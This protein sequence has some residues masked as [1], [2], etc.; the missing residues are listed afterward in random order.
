MSVTLQVSNVLLIWWLGHLSRSINNIFSFFPLSSQS[1]RECSMQFLLFYANQKSL[2]S[3]WASFTPTSNKVATLA[4]IQQHMT[5]KNL[6][7]SE[8]QKEVGT[9]EMGVGPWE[10]SYLFLVPVSVKNPHPCSP[11]CVRKLC[12]V[13]RV[14]AMCTQVYWAPY[15]L[16]RTE[17]MRVGVRSRSRNA[18]LQSG[19]CWFPPADSDLRINDTSP[20]SAPLS[21]GKSR[22]FSHTSLK[23]P[24]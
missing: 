4:Q 8:L 2:E 5:K 14:P 22:I 3:Y 10:S 15:L 16:T 21:V 23:D 17:G 1:S 24:Q 19:C 9:E 13:T 11:W 18:G 6:Q 12:W 20:E 7:P